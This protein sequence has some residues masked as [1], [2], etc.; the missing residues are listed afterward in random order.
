MKILYLCFDPS[1]DLAAETGGAVHVRGMIRAMRELGHEITVLGT[2]VSRPEWIESQTAARVIPCGITRLNRVLEK[3]IRK[4]N[5]V[6]H[7]PLRR[8]PDAVR[9]L[10]NGTFFNTAAKIVRRLSP[11]FIYE[12]YSLW[13]IA[14]FTLAKRYRVPF[15]LEVNAPLV[16]EQ[17][18][19]RQKLAWPR[20]ARW[21]ECRVWQGANPVIVVSEPLHNHLIEAGVASEKI[22]VLPNAVDAAWFAAEPGSIGPPRDFHGRDKFVLAF[23][24]SFKPWH[25]ADFLLSVFEEFHKLQPSSRLLLIGDGP[26]KGE[27]QEKAR[28]AG[29]EKA[30]VFTGIVPHEEIRRYLARVDVALAPYPRL[31]NFYYSPL[32]LFEYMAA[33][34]VVVASNAGQIPQIIRHRVTGLL[35]EP[36]DRAGL[37]NCLCELRKDAALREEL[38]RNARKA[39]EAFTWERNAARVIEWIRLKVHRGNL[40]VAA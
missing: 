6:L 30:V 28:L 25:G 2:C 34:R 21:M 7:R 38:G 26:L 14:G 11:E 15:A 23:V 9:L 40:R 27:L 32:K 31:D 37:L 3:T 19:Y 12:R 24:G 36:G 18:R 33:G 39:S 22:R 17:Q 13:G 4:T 10:H 20:L 35:Y 16:Y 8:Y 5:N 29:L 1:I